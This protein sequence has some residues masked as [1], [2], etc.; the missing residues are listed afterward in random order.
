MNTINKCLMIPILSMA[1]YAIPLLADQA[2]VVANH[3]A[4]D[5]LHTS[6]T[7]TTASAEDTI[8]K[9]ETVKMLVKDNR[10]ADAAV[11]LKGDDSFYFRFGIE[12]PDP[13]E[14]SFI[15]FFTTGLKAPSLGNYL[16]FI[17]L[18]FLVVSWFKRLAALRKI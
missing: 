16:F 8:R 5:M 13:V 4:V 2:A 14:P 9:A 17:G 7:L 18:A 1:L 6:T 12:K 3:N 10:M 15:N 11:S